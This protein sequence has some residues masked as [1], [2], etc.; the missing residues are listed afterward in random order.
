MC[1]EKGKMENEMEKKQHKVERK[2]E[3]KGNNSMREQR[4]RLVYYNF[5]LK[6]SRFPAVAVYQESSLN[7]Q[8]LAEKLVVR[9]ANA[10]R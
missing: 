7:S 9:L 4:H 10:P 5:I 1:I 3:Q 6:C 2:H 8:F